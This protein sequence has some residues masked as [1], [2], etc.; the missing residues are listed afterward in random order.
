MPLSLVRS[1]ETV[2][3]SSVRGDEGIRRHLKSLGFVSGSQVHV[4]TAGG[5]NIIVNVK[6]TR[7]GLDSRVAQHV[8]TT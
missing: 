8:M 2:A 3:V 7:L 4:V 1:G 6:G 5:S